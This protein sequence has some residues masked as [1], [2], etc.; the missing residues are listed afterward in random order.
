MAV[1]VLLTAVSLSFAI[2]SEEIVRLTQLKTSDDVLSQLIQASP[3]DKP[4]TPSQVILLKENGV[5]ETILESL[6]TGTPVVN[7]QALPPQE[8]DSHWLNESARFYYTTTQSGEKRLVVTN[9]DESGKR[10]GPP[11]P[12]HKESGPQMAY[13]PPVYEAPQQS[14]SAPEP[15]QYYEPQQAPY[16]NY[17]GGSN[18]YPPSAVVRELLCALLQ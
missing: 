8:G 11:P 15:P 4:L 2:T 3:L 16:P 14:Y 12:L 6:I 9:L 17:G 10:M 13:A 18:W 1:L 5:S 7:Q